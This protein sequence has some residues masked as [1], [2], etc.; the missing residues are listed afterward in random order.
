[1][2]EKLYHITKGAKRFSY[3]DYLCVSLDGFE[4]LW[5]DFI[6]EGSDEISLTGYFMEKTYLDYWESLERANALR[7]R[8]KSMVPCS[9]TLKQFEELVLFY[10]TVDLLSVNDQEGL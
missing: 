5:E 9:L 1:M 8:I 10:T 7:A 6:G 2:K 4:E 3:V